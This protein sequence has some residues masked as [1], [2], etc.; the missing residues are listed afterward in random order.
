MNVLKQ[1]DARWFQ[2]LFLS[3]FLL[4]GAVA[5]DFALT[6][7]Q[8]AACFASGL[9]TQALWQWGLR[10]PGRRQ[11]GAYLS[12]IIS[13]FGICILVR[14]QN[15]WAHPLLACVAMSSKYLLR[16]GRADCKSHVFNPANLAAFAAW[17]WTSGTW[18]SP[19]QWGASSLTA[20]WFVALGG[21]VTQ[22]ISRWDVSLSFLGSWAVLLAARLIWLDYAWDPG[23]AIWVQ[24]MSNGATLLFAFFMISD[25]MTTP[26]HRA[27]RMAYAFSVALA[28]F[29]WQFVLFRPHGLIVVLFYASCLVPA[30]NYVFRRPRFEW[31]RTALPLN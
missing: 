12:A 18:L 8:I 13:C 27:A 26:Q 2:I 10:L 11:W 24:Q 31:Q 30:I 3:S 19:G 23:A 9:S 20:L 16:V 5:R 14:S 21:L 1:L 6:L 22:R 15:L 28:A 29:V 7:P 4:L 25:P 17:A